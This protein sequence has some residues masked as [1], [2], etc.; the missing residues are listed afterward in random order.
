MGV[1]GVILIGG[2]VGAFAKLLMPERDPGGLVVPIVLGV[3]GAFTATC[4][5]QALNLYDWGEPAGYVGAAIGAMYLPLRLHP[6]LPSSSST[7]ALVDAP[8]RQVAPRKKCHRNRPARCA[9]G[10]P[11]ARNRRTGNGH[12]PVLLRSA[13]VRIG[14]PI[15]RRDLSLLP[16]R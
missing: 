11:A 8:A 14:K 2:I 4:L 15:H 5:G 13:S 3:A 12:L 16:H 7:L 6:P 1:F 10:R 9:H